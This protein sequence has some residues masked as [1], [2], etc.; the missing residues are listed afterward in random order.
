MD[1]GCYRKTEIWISRLI[2]LL[3]K[4]GK[5][6][7]NS[8]KSSPFFLL[9]SISIDASQYWILTRH[10]LFTAEKEKKNALSIP[11]ISWSLLRRQSLNECKMTA[12]KG[13]QVSHT[14]L[15]VSQ[16]FGPG[17]DRSVKAAAGQH[18][19]AVAFGAPAWRRDTGDSRRRKGKSKDAVM[20][21]HG[22]F[23]GQGAHQPGSSKPRWRC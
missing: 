11:S 1:E 21:M 10:I 22:P 9:F 7:K 12:S 6:K 4:K 13:S 3:H 8:L 23:R 5:K 14:N 2:W 17:K 16:E 18:S 15:H 19:R 20:G